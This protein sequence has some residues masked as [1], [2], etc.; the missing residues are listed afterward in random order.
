MSSV[1]E[2]SPAK[3]N[4]GDGFPDGGRFDNLVARQTVLVIPVSHHKNKTLFL[5]WIGNQWAESGLRDIDFDH[6]RS[7]P[8]DCVDDRNLVSQIIQHP[9]LFVKIWFSIKDC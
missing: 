5:E 7:H 3:A 6:R 1:P 4:S 8:S 9:Q 2:N